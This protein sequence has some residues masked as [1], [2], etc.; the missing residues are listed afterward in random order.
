MSHKW[1]PGCVFS[2]GREI[3][4]CGQNLDVVQTP[5]IRVTVATSAS[6]LGQGLERRRR[7]VPETACSPGMSCGGLHVRPPWA[8]P[9]CTRL[10][11]T[12]LS[13]EQPWGA[14]TSGGC[15]PLVA[16]PPHPRHVLSAVPPRLPSLC[17]SLR[18]L[19]T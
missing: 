1:F 15:G 14:G 10:A 5:R 17:P 7:V 11:V 18:S 16:A 8:S 4:V 9:A 13:P 2:G 19:A 12:Q 3:R 6:R